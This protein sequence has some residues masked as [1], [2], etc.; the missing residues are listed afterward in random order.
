MLELPPPA[1]AA[2]PDSED[3]LFHAV[4][5]GDV[6]KVKALI[7]EKADPNIVNDMGFTPLIYAAMEGHEVVVSTLIE[8]GAEVNGVG[9]S[10]SD[11]FLR[12]FAQ[13]FGLPP[14]DTLEIVGF[15]SRSAVTYAAR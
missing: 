15:F 14:R 7:R 3:P 6:K 10:S 5:A 11:K 9:L 4:L 12:G 1:I 8:Y 13:T 2:I